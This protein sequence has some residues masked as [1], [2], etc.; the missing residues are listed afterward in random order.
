MNQEV[1]SQEEKDRGERETESLDDPPVST[2]QG[3]GMLG[4]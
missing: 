4:A 1:P 2:A 3:G